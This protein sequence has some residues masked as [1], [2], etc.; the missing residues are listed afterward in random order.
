MKYWTD[1]IPFKQLVSLSISSEISFLTVAT[2]HA[3]YFLAATWLIL[4]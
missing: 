1:E 4:V 2:E 3:S